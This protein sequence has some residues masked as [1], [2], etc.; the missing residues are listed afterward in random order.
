M[1]NTENCS[2]FYVCEDDLNSSKLRTP[3]TT[4]RKVITVSAKLLSGFW[5]TTSYNEI[6]VI[7][8]LRTTR[9]WSNL[10]H[11][12]LGRQASSASVIW[13]EDQSDRI[14]L[15]QIVTSDHQLSWRKN[16]NLELYKIR[17]FDYNYSLF[18]DL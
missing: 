15:W 11:I 8:L 10:H 2:R 16:H 4:N 17:Q 9:F 18:V 1:T 7:K 12:S 13:S 3:I 14:R 6:L 5:Y